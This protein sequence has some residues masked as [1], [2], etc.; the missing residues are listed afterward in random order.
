ME[1]TAINIADSDDPLST[2]PMPRY[3]VM[4]ATLRN[5]LYMLAHYHFLVI[6]Y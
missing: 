5:T 2:T 4:L 6:L 1:K 3:N